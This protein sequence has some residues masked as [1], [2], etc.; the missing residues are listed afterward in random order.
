MMFYILFRHNPPLSIDV[1]FHSYHTH[2]RH[3]ELLYFVAKFQPGNFFVTRTH[4]YYAFACV[5]SLV[6]SI[7]SISCHSVLTSHCFRSPLLYPQQFLV[8]LIIHSHPY[9]PTGSFKH[10]FH[11]IV[12][13]HSPQIICLILI[14]TQSDILYPVHIPYFIFCIY[15]HT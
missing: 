7:R 6:F 9:T 2:C 12:D 3:I 10:H 8:M 1:L 13:P 15:P 4:L 14:I 5:F 11:C